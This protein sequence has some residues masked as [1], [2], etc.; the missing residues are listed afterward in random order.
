MWKFCEAINKNKIYYERRNV[1]VKQ[2]KKE[3]KE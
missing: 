1:N 3:T 2:N